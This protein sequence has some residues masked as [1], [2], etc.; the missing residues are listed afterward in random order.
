MQGEHITS[1]RTPTRF[2]FFEEKSYFCPHIAECAKKLGK[3]LSAIFPPPVIYSLEIIKI[4]VNKDMEAS[5]LDT[6]NESIMN[7]SRVNGNN[8]QM[9]VSAARILSQYG[10]SIMS[11]TC[12][13]AVDGHSVTRTLAFAL[14]D[15]VMRRDTDKKVFF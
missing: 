10:T 2:S 15:A 1:F 3:K 8:R 7:N 9:N 13:D 4:L 14:L 12:Q 6:M 5:R 11:V